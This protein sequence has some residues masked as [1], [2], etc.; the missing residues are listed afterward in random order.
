MDENLATYANEKVDKFTQNFDNYRK[1]VDKLLASSGEI[2]KNEAM[3]LLV[4]IDMAYLTLCK[5]FDEYPEDD[6]L[7]DATLSD[8]SQTLLGYKGRVIEALNGNKEEK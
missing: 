5:D 8:I 7:I 2:D 6:K 3:D 4:K 1:E